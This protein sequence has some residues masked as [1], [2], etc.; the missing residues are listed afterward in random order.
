MCGDI[1]IVN[2]GREVARGDLH[3]LKLLSRGV[4][5]VSLTLDRVPD[6]LEEQLRARG[7]R[8]LR[9]VDGTVEVALEEDEASVLALVAD[10]A[11]RAGVL[12][13]EIAGAD[14]EDVFVELTKE[15]KAS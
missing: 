4:Y 13:V 3:A 9:V 1:L 14:L 12:R 6:G 8:R 10:I 2:R 7:P 5:E 15:G 11:R